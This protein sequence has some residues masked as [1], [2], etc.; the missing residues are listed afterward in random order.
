MS[1][2]EPPGPI[3]KPLR[4]SAHAHLNRSLCKLTR[5]GLTD[6]PQLFFPAVPRA[7]Q[8]ALCDSEIP[9]VGFTLQPTR[10]I[11]RREWNVRLLASMM[12]IGVQCHLHGGVNKGIYDYCLVIQ[13]GD[14]A[15][16][17]ACADD[18]HEHTRYGRFIK[19]LQGSSLP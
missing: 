13:I 6:V 4:I 16:A 14:A 10:E 1:V 19:R 2:L 17:R 5:G 8:L 12:R 7:P 9:I 15:Q 18:K 3:P 11:E